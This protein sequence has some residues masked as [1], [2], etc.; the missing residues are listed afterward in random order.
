MPKPDFQRFFESAP[1]PYLV[2]DPSLRVVAVSDAY[3]EAAL[4][5][6]EDIV[7]L[8]IFDL[9]PNGPGAQDIAGRKRAEQ[10]LRESEERYRT[11]FNSIDQGFCIIEM[12]IEPGAR[13][14]YRFIEINA[15]F[16]R[17]STLVDATGKWMRELR[18][19]H[20]EHWFEIYRD[21][22][23]TGEPVRFERPARQLGDRWFEV[24]AFRVGSPEQKRVG[25]L[26]TDI[27]ARKRA[28]EA[29]RESEQRFRAL[30]E[31]SVDAVFLT[32]ADGTI[33]KANPAACAMFGM[34]EEEIIR[35]GR[36]G[37][38]DTQHPH[39]EELLAVRRATG[40]ARGEL[41][42]V[43]KDGAR[44]QCEVSSA[45]VGA[46]GESFVIV[47]DITGRKRDEQ[48]LRD[49]EARYRAVFS[50][51]AVGIG[52]INFS[53]ARWIEV[54]EAFCRMVGYTR[55][56]LATKP[57]P[58]I[59]H[60]ED[61]DLDMI[62][63]RRMAAGQLDSYTVEKR[64]IHKRGHPVWA[65]LALSLVRDEAGRPDYEIAVIEDITLRKQAEQ[66]LRASE[67]SLKRAQEIA[68]LG[69]WEL[70]VIADR[71]TWS[72]EVYRIFGLEPR[73]FAATYEAFLER[74]HPDDRAAVDAAYAGSVREG[75]NSYEIEHRVVRKD[76]G[77]VR[78]VHE[79]CQ[80]VRD[81][82][83]RI[84]LSLGMVHDITDR[85]LAEDALRESERQFRDLADSMPQLVWTAD[86]DGAITYVNRQLHSQLGVSGEV[87]LGDRWLQLVHPE[88]R[89]R[90]QPIWRH[91][92]ETGESY[93][94]EYRLRAAGG[95]YRWFLA[96]GV[97]IRGND[98]RIAK[99]YGTATD[100][101]E[102]KRAEERLRQTQK[103]ESIGLLAGGIAHDFNNLLTG[104]IGNASLALEESVGA[105]PAKRIGE[106]IRSAERAATLTR[107][108]LAYSGRGR[109]IIHDIDVSEAVNGIADLVQFSIPKSVALQISVTR[110]LPLVQMDPSQLQQVL[111]NLVINAGEAIGEGN[112]GKV[113]ISTSLARFDSVF[114]DSAGQ[115]IE[116]GRYVCIEV[117]DTGHGISEDARSKIFDPFFTTKFAGRGL[118]L[119]AVAGIIR[120]QKG[121]IVVESEP[122]RGSA[123]SVYLPLAGA[124]PHT[125]EEVPGGAA[126]A[127]VLVVDD[128]D[129]VRNV[130]A[131]VLRRKGYRALT[132]PDGPEAL[133][134]AGRE[135]GAIDAAVL[136]MV[137][138]VM[139]ASEL[140]PA[141]RSLRPDIKVLL[142]SGY[143][144]TEARRLAR[145][146][147][148][149]A[150]IQKP[151]T[152]QQILHAVERLL[153]GPAP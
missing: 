126:R 67:A 85:K 10:A 19:G 76:N 106:V 121:A 141:L 136:D 82:Q 93:E 47:R 101:D 34:T 62:P 113:A 45:I 46:G 146:H 11:L 16:E 68:H 6:R 9:F 142:T 138:P 84:V 103:L 107:Q 131:T 94:V 153:E 49:R 44:F 58:E 15:A 96:R 98:G 148:G 109:F 64:F 86:A 130:I 18:P 70:D 8:Y 40:S 110:R 29:L 95:E 87:P 17:Q 88:D 97:P 12:K 115:Q 144:E 51:A 118:G 73:E 35:A 112:P 72:D 127:T 102:T 147:T 27:T 151:Y 63:F 4:A 1:G 125:A 61:I 105:E 133:A 122:G 71:L 25:V 89:E 48:A 114:T 53:D 28:D 23:L 13:L 92:V 24:Y 91:C 108:L 26:F 5:R 41:T 120:A 104:I 65:R 119:A 99:W 124:E 128:D 66:A 139:G 42:C 38:V 56:E 57:W 81:A 43:R 132:A 31:N 37:L 30:F 60:P 54:N 39:L 14:D 7:G 79:K 137:M 90:I 123:F 100:I 77:E 111:M 129:D 3:L 36:S 33:L 152:A 20:E 59:T 116:P 117:R 134:I 140:L 69:S 145:A 83:G 78:Y 149:T 22:A 143:S 74:V 75:R 135:E 150:Y 2:L 52:R 80:H 50:G 21:V 55:E 32:V